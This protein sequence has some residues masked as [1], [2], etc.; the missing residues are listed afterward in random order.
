MTRWGW[1][2]KGL[3]GD[4]TNNV[5]LKTYFVSINDSELLSLANMV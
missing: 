4:F 1:L 3:L 5:I 2:F